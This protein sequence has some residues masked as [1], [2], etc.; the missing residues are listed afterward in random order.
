MPPAATTPLTLTVLI[1]VVTFFLDAFKNVIDDPVGLNEYQSNGQM[2]DAYDFIVVGGGSAGSVVAARLV[3]RLHLTKSETRF[4]TDI[5]ITY[6]FV[7]RP[8]ETI[9]IL[10]LSP[11]SHS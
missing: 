9:V 11:K 7:V 5:T 3:G 2:R 8:V 4:N 10:S 6:F 1:A